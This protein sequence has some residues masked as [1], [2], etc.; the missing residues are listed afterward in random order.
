MS[1]NHECLRALPRNVR[2]GNCGR[3]D[4]TRKHA[5][6]TMHLRRGSSREDAADK[7]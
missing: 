2:L 7:S 3:G 5:L 1:T 6:S 4:K